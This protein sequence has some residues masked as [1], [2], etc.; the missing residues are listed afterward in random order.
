MMQWVYKDKKSKG[1]SCMS[2]YKNLYYERKFLTCGSQIIW[3]FQGLQDP[4]AMLNLGDFK[5]DSS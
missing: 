4:Q 3:A 1:I 2:L 5:R